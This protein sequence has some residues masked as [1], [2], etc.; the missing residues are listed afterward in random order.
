M[1]KDLVHLT[2]NL[3][4]LYLFKLMEKIKKSLEFIKRENELYGG[5]STG[6]RQPTCVELYNILVDKIHLILSDT[7]FYVN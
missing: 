3:N 1:E 2:S 6:N 4:K 5:F 7:D